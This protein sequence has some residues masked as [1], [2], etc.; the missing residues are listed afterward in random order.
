MAEITPEKQPWAVQV[1]NK[2]DE[3]TKTDRITWGG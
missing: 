1:A 3:L 2:I